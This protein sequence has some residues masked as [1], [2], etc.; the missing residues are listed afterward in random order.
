[1]RPELCPSRP[2]SVVVLGNSLTVLSLPGREGVDDG[3]Y[4][5]VL[6][7]RLAA[8]QVPASVVLEGR[9][10]EFA[11]DALNRFETCVRRY[12][13]DVLVLHYGLNESQPWLLPVPVLRHLLSGR[14]PTTHLGAWYRATWTPPVWRRVRAYRRWASARIGT[15]TWQ[16]SPPRFARA[17]RQLIGAA[18]TEGRP[19]VLVVDVDP[20][21]P[22]L[23]HHLAGMP[24]RHAIVQQV[25]QDVVDGF[26]DPEVRLVASSSLRELAG[27][28]GTG[29]GLH[30]S[31][32]GHRV[33]GEALADQVL[34]WLATEPPPTNRRR[35]DESLEVPADP[36]RPWTPEGRP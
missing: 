18:R 32:A 20:P 8:A 3:L 14:Q 7:D 27:T 2:L 25:L 4:A 29:D 17:M 6:R 34:A 36:P 31:P 23:A 16:T 11:T 1:M 22:S 30:Y 19:L 26:G 28:A 10:F 24:E 12:R 5:E 21:G 35:A 33:I 9:T 15:T 13:P